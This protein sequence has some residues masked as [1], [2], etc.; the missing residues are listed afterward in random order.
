[1][2][3]KRLDVVATTMK[4]LGTGASEGTTAISQIPIDINSITKTAIIATARQQALH[5][6]VSDSLNNVVQKLSQE[7]IANG[8]IS[9]LSNFKPAVL[10]GNAIQ[11]RN[12]G[13]VE[14]STPIT[15]R[16]TARA[17]AIAGL[18]PATQAIRDQIAKLQQLAD[19]KNM[20]SA[21]ANALLS[22]MGALTSKLNALN[23]DPSKLQQYQQQ[24]DILQATYNKTVDAIDAIRKAYDLRYETL[25][26]LK[27]DY[28][29]A[30]KKIRDTIAIY[31]KLLHLP[32]IPTSIN[33]P[34]L[35]KLPNINFSK[36]DFKQ[37]FSNLVTAIV[38]ASK[39][40]SKTSLENSRKQNQPKIESNPPKP[41]DFFTKAV[42]NA[43]KALGAVEAR[44]NALNAAKQAAKDAAAGALTG[45]INRGVAGVAAAQ[46]RIASNIGNLSTQVENNIANIQQAKDKA[47]T[48]K[49]GME[50]NFDTVAQDTANLIVRAN[51]GLQSASAALTGEQVGVDI[52]ANTPVTSNPIYTVDEQTKLDA[53]QANI[54]AFLNAGA[55]SNFKVGVG[56]GNTLRAAL[57]QSLK[58]QEFKTEFPLAFTNNLYDTRN[59][60]SNINGVYLVVTAVYQTVPIIVPAPPAPQPPEDTTATTTIPP[61]EKESPT[62][63]SVREP[64]FITATTDNVAP[65]G[66]N[67]IRVVDVGSGYNIVV[68]DTGATVKRTGPFP[69]RNFNPGN[70]ENGS[71]AQSMG[72]LN[73]PNKGA[74]SRYAIFPNYETGRLALKTLLQSSKYNNLRITAAIAKYAPAF[75]NNTKAYQNTVIAAIGADEVVGLLTER[76]LNTMMDIIERIEGYRQPGTV[77]AVTSPQSF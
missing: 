12:I 44:V 48:F 42:S 19:T 21:Q 14:G 64:V 13:S 3:D 47:D 49:K 73:I 46:Q 33:W 4:N 32:E 40:A 16:S 36:A 60:I 8:T 52:T 27:L 77:T 41:E 10:Q 29:N 66:N 67:I 25:K 15:T 74:P 65:T 37:Q 6:G 45:E 23:L 20:L 24:L 43:K 57:N 68:M 17:T 55:H 56:K 22:Q 72:A 34:K 7:E 28:R 2:S 76:Q 58:L 38:N 71:F 59:E 61:S 70:L 62:A 50:K 39:E 63:T 35:P 54:T 51:A 11:R 75:E 18:D 5:G 69:W 1:M 26:K 9:A 53:L 31:E 30:K